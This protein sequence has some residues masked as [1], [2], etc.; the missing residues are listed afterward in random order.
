MLTAIQATLL[1]A[2]FS[3]GLRASL[4]LIDREL[5][6]RRGASVLDVNFW[7]N[8][9][10]L[11]VLL[12]LA[13]GMG[14]GQGV[15]SA[16]LNG[17]TLVFAGLVQLVAYTFSYCLGRF[18]VAA[19]TV[20]SKMPDLLIPV[21]I[22]L[23]AGQWSW[24]NYGFAVLTC[25]VCLPI[26]FQ[27]PR[28]TTLSGS[29]HAVLIAAL[30][31]A[32]VLQGSLSS[33]LVPSET[34]LLASFEFATAVIFWRTLWSSVALLRKGFRWSSSLWGSL[35]AL[36]FVRSLASIGTQLTFVLALAQGESAAAWAVFNSTSL[37]AVALAALVLKE[38]PTRPELFAIGGIG[39][40]TAAR[41]AV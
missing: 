23:V 37:I 32:L 13:A 3:A 40:L 5:F 41:L 33:S 8:L 26:W 10:P 24:S 20:Y 1:I 39:V 15:L 31:A 16:L 17:R 36:V 14:H 27:R 30:V 11:V 34:S 29:P 18:S 9:L 12:A 28:T 19:T 2:F 22:W 35:Q 38:P 6:G 25:V 7:N 4:N 21:G